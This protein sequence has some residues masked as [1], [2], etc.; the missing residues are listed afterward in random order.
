MPDKRKPSNA[1]KYRLADIL[2]TTLAVFYLLHP[3][4]L[5]FQKAMRQKHKKD[6]LETLFRV[7]Q[8]PSSPQ[9][10]NILDKIEPS[11]LEG[12]FAEGLKEA[13]RQGVYWGYQVLDGEMPI[14]CDGTGYFSSHDIS[15]QHCLTMTHEKKDGSIETTNYHTMLA[16]TIVKHDKSVVLPLVPEFIRNEDGMDKQDCERNGFKRYFARHF[17]ALRELKPIF[18]G[19]DLY[20]CHS[21]CSLIDAH[22]MSFIF[23]CKDESHPYIKEQTEDAPFEEH[24]RTEWNGKN[25]LEHRYYWLKGIEN[26]ADP[27][28]IYVNYLKYEIWNVEKE[29]V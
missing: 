24:R 26:R 16:F 22:R 29:K 25:H 23:T 21:I 5:S 2:K 9:I 10:T 18:L 17:E 28:F 11:E 15:C 14:A 7:R 13:K 6:N 20:S 19:D 27:K 1:T 3:S 4:L 8:A 12:V